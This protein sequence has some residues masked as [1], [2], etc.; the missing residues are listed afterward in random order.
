MKITNTFSNSI[1]A[2]VDAAK[3]IR[4]ELTESDFSQALCDDIDLILEEVVCNIIQH[5]YPNQR[6]GEISITIETSPEPI[7]IIEDDSDSFDPFIAETPNAMLPPGQR[8]I[9]GLGIFLTKNRCLSHSY[10]TESSRNK[11]TMHVKRCD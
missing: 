3:A 5:G 2:F 6:A 8:E 11:L 10:E 1:P 4:Q 9:G 7:I